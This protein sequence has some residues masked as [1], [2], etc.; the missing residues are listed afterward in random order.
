L[1]EHLVLRPF[2]DEADY[3]CLGGILTA[4]ENADSLPVTVSAA[5]I[6]ESLGTSP[7][8]DL[9]RDLVIVE[10]DGQVVG[11][12]RVRW[13]EEPAR[14]TYGLTGY[15][16]PEWRRKGIGRTL[17]IWLEERARAIAGEQL[18]AAPSFLHINVTQYKRGLHALARQTGYGIKESW[19][20]MVR[21]SLENIPAA[22]LPEGL[23]VRPV[24]PEHFPAI[25]Y[26]VEEAYVPEGG[27]PPTGKIPEDFQKDPNF[28]PELWQ[29]AWEVRGAKVVGSVMAYINHLENKQLGIRRG[30]TEG[31]STVP[32]WQRRGVARALIALSLKAQRE[33]GLTESA[34]VCSGEKPD[35]YKLYV[36]CGF[37]EVK[38]DTVYEKPLFD[39]YPCFPCSLASHE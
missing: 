15:L 38:R 26:A 9:F 1:P 19:A 5:E 25:W 10:V 3:T 2:R 23:E 39:L 13:W 4:S 14:R 8:F 18:T 22:P 30:Y 27:P 21:P 11:F 16:L 35:N 32:S 34:L 20:L 24:L 17:L 29:V 33:V 28:Q 31:I 12:G 7:R 36:S 37:Q 6:A